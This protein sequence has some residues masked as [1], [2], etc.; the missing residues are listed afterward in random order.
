MGA[1][2]ETADIQG[3]SSTI[4]QTVGSENVLTE[5]RDREFY[6]TDLSCRDREIA[7]M[8]VRP[9]N[10]DQLSAVV[11]AATKAGFNVVPRGGGMSYTSGYT[12]EKP[13]SVLI[14]MQSMNRVLEINE[15]DMYVVVECGCTWKD[16]YETLQAK[17]LRTPYFGPLSGKYATIGGALSQN[18]LFLG[19]GVHHTVAESV[20]GLRVVL[21]D[22]TV[23]VTGSGAH[24]NSNPFWRHFGPDIT[25]LFTADTGA[26]GLK[27][28]AVLRL[29]Q[30]PPATT[31][32][33]FKFDKLAHMLEAQARIARL[34]VCSECYGFDPYYNSGFEKQGITF[35]EGAS[36]AGK[37][38]LKGGLKGIAKAMRMAFTGKRLLRDVPYSL[39]MTF[40]AINDVVA[41]EHQ[42]LCAS[43][44]QEEGGT[45]MANTIP[46]VFRAQPFGSVRTILLGSEGELWLPVH[47]FFPLSRAVE[48]GEATEKWLAEK[49][50]ILEKYDIRTSYLTCFS[51]AEFVIEPS[52]YWKDKLGEFRLSLI[53]EEFAEK[54]KDIPEDK[55][56]RG[57]VLSL[58]EELRDLYDNLG[59]CHLQIGKYYEYKALMENE[60][61]WGVL[62]GVKS[63]LDPER[64]IN[65]GSLG[66]R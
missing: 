7:S 17:G 36:I 20:I 57:V 63:M 42:E 34:G 1:Q 10:I 31:Y 45:E 19:S 56:K 44:C 27:A 33:S 50:P 21:A 15:K 2:T 18:S 24:K 5:E 58:R 28:V 25:G 14:D 62:E 8:V 26:F 43:I 61:L 52:F 32:M 35:T 9:G 38:A 41:T 49:R 53:E 11:G 47:G 30:S 65:P 4:A 16:L 54:W 22:G 55:E 23:L 66:L 48:A 59:G 13:N 37:V 6:S 64:K 46:T 60:A 12:P 40:D 39:H 3:L 51:G 29:I